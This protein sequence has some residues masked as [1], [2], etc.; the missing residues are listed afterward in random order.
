VAATKT[1]GM[2]RDALPINLLMRR[3]T[4][5]V[6]NYDQ[7]TVFTTRDNIR[8]RASYR[9]RTKPFSIQSPEKPH[10]ERKSSADE[11]SN[12]YD[13]RPKAPT[14]DVVE[15]SSPALSTA[16]LVP[17]RP[18]KL[19]PAPRMLRKHRRHEQIIEIN[20]TL[21]PIIDVDAD[22]AVDPPPTL[23]PLPTIIHKPSTVGSSS[24]YSTQ[25]GEDRQFG[26]GPPNFTLGLPDPGSPIP[27]P[28]LAMSHKPSNV[29]SVYSNQSGEERMFG[30]PP[31][32]L[33]ALG[34]DRRRFSTWTRSS[35]SMYSI[36]DEQS[37]PSAWVIPRAR[38]AGGG[39]DGPQPSRLSQFSCISTDMR[40]EKQ[41][42]VDIA[43]DGENE[44]VEMEKN[45]EMNRIL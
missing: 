41:S 10:F 12:A 22:P 29:S 11:K 6:N 14:A 31:H 43:Y 25:S 39:A 26:G 20:P 23:S 33:A 13:R 37:P 7:C 2:C 34:Q 1:S 24:V 40:P 44:E 21:S 18:T 8:R 9:H 45:S 42:A 19:S 15:P 36:A 5:G 38:N 3:N 27:R 35:G 32:F 17:S 16:P 28:P 4:H 30:V